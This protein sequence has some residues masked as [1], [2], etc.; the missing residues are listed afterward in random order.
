L[1]PVRV[2]GTVKLP[3]G[4]CNADVGAIK[5]SVGAG[6]S[7]VNVS[8]LLVPP[9]VVTLRVPAPSVAVAAMV[10]FAVTV[11][12]V[13]VP[14]I[15]QVTPLADAFTA[16]APVRL[17]PVRVTAGAVPCVPDVGA[18]EVSVGAGTDAST[19]NVWVLLVPPGVVTL[20]VWAPVVAL[21]AIVQV[22]LTEVAVGVP[23]ITQVTPVPLTFTAVAPVRLVPVRVTAGAVPCVPE[24]GAIEVSVG[25][26]ADEF[27]V[28]VLVL[29]V[30]LGVV[31]LTVW[32]PV[33]ALDAIVQVAW[34]VVAVGVPV[35]T[36]VTPVPLT[37][38][39][40]APVRLVPVRVTAGA[41][42]CVPD[43]GAIEVSVGIVPTVNVT[44]LLV[45]PGVVTL[46]FRGPSA[47]L[48]AIVQFALTEVAVG[49][50][51]IAQVMPVPDTFTAVAPV[52]L[53][54]AR[55]TG[56][57]L[58]VTTPKGPGAGGVAEVGAIEVSVGAG[59]TQLPV[60]PTGNSTA[61]TS[62]QIPE[63]GL[64]LPKKSVAGIAPAARLTLAGM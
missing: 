39:A 30:P 5:V 37:F 52:R 2:T 60:A 14:V 27:T 32:A 49:V 4:G 43:V 6:T 58:K 50:P 19:V 18:I 45:P 13:V 53:V 40:V 51:V 9:G 8:V 24:L 1:V 16:V 59:A 10:Q 47:A 31:T 22:A 17:V 64:L 61:P 41:V 15:T 46:T 11:V 12:A 44:V 21:D 62:T 57:F 3:K 54:P 7:T 42:P 55:V 29:L 38:T 63:S 36:Q 33:V 23:L 48:D 35:I 34:T 25:A 56:T 26:G 20:T 28:N